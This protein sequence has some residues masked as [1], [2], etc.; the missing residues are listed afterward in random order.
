MNFEITVNKEYT[1]PMPNVFVNRIPLIHSANGFQITKNPAIAENQ[2]N[3][4]GW[5]KN[6]FGAYNYRANANAI[7][8][9]EA[10]SQEMENVEVLEDNVTSSNTAFSINKQITVENSSF[11]ITEIS[12]RKSFPPINATD[13]EPSS[14]EK[15][16]STT[17]ISAE[18]PQEVEKPK[19]AVQTQ[20]HRQ[21]P[22]STNAE[23][24]IHLS[25]SLANDTDS[26]ASN[27]LCTSM[28]KTSRSNASE[29]K[30]NK[31]VASVLKSSENRLFTVVKKTASGEISEVFRRIHQNSDSRNIKKTSEVKDPRTLTKKKRDIRRHDSRSKT[32]KD[33]I[34]KTSRT[35]KS[36][37]E[38]E[39]QVAEESDSDESFKLYLS[40]DAEDKM[41]ENANFNISSTEIDILQRTTDMFIEN[42]TK[43]SEQLK[44]P[45][46]PLTRS[47]D[48]RT[49]KTKS[50]SEHHGTN[51]SI[52][53]KNNLTECNPAWEKANNAISSLN[54]VP[55]TCN[56]YPF[57][58][59]QYPY[60]VYPNSYS[61]PQDLY[62]DNYQIP[63]LNDKL[64][65]YQLQDHP[66]SF[67]NYQTF[68]L[69]YPPPCPNGQIRYSVGQ[70]PLPV[71]YPNIET[72]Q[73]NNNQSPSLYSNDLSLTN[74]SSAE[75]TSEEKA[76]LFEEFS[77]SWHYKGVE[78]IHRTE[79]IEF[80]NR[81]AT[82][83]VISSERVN[84]PYKSSFKSQLKIHAPKS[85]PCVQKN[86][87]L[88][89]CLPLASPKPQVPPEDANLNTFV[90]PK[91]AMNLGLLDVHCVENPPVIL[92]S[93]PLASTK[94]QVLQE[95]MN[96]KTFVVPK[97]AMKLEPLPVSS[98]DPELLKENNN[99]N[100]N[101]LLVQ[102][103]VKKIQP[104]IK[105]LGKLETYIPADKLFRSAA[106]S[107]EVLMNI[108]FWRPA[109]FE[110]SSS[111][112]IFFSRMQLVIITF[113]IMRV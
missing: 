69:N 18:E 2:S 25:I 89:E 94:P 13:R 70:T 90:V 106:K 78:E 36:K 66:I 72:P 40:D 11:Q 76:Q 55:L 104:D 79:R 22:D 20:L 80:K 96:L 77:A 32:S 6:S 93:L 103:P 111:I 62:P 86:P 28:T 49:C 35:K 74:S 38:N 48:P 4:S 59:A 99:L 113:S 33:Q 3:Q 57:P 85:M 61:N 110:V 81:K 17:Q 82:P 73:S 54:N 58:N 7:P 12:R 9:N 42:I 1:G 63:Y 100:K 43:E 46:V 44:S 105:K 101:V 26:D 30:R 5:I 37:F 107:D 88:I 16:V 52:N 71:P 14:S 109:E 102:E 97:P 65:Y 108:V 56:P 87:V 67:Q 31:E 27:A 91:L 84:L 60:L 47:V 39:G 95:D 50:P 10:V 45:E 41:D 53:I 21:S 24:E 75:K 29:E 34:I 19:E 98:P 51:C 15:E 64:A 68:Y 92:E 8:Q 83:K 23:N 112:K